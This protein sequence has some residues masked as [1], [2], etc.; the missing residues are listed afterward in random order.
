MR[1]PLAPP[2]Q[3]RMAKLQTLVWASVLTPEVQQ[4]AAGNVSP[5]SRRGRR[6]RALIRLWESLEHSHFTEKRSRAG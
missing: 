6:I 3:R 4:I 2:D 1:H 5:G